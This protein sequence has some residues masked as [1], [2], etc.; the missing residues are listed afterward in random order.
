MLDERYNICIL[1]LAKCNSSL[2]K[3]IY[4]AE[5]SDNDCKSVSYFIISLRRIGSSSF[6]TYF[7]FI[8]ILQINGHRLLVSKVLEVYVIIIKMMRTR[9]SWLLPPHSDRPFLH[10]FYNHLCRSEDIDQ[11]LYATC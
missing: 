2:K 9:N 11:T 6:N 10:T 7:R 4:N 3:C 5:Q 1:V 8:A